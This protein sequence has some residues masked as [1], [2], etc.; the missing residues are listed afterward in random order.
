MKYLISD[1]LNNSH[2]VLLKCFQVS[3]DPS[4]LGEPLN[5]S[6]LRLPVCG[7]TCSGGGCSNT[8]SLRF[9]PRWRLLLLQDSDLRIPG[10][11]CVCVCRGA[12]VLG[13]A[14]E[15]CWRFDQMDYSGRQRHSADES[16][17]GAEL[18]RARSQIRWAA[19]PAMV[20]WR[21]VEVREIHFENLRN[22]L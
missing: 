11:L 17:R 9:D 5:H 8:C 16:K 18:G 6:F 19:R 21:K 13:V 22:T 10:H 1:H 15:C 7:G 14:Q 12:Q 20:Q 4:S 3:L 2:L